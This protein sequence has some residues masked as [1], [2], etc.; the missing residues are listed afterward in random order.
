MSPASDPALLAAV[1]EARAALDRLAWMKPD[2]L[3]H[4][5]DVRRIEKAAKIA[6]QARDRIDAAVA[7]ESAGEET[8]GESHG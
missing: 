7:S 2:R 8:K 5:E 6:A 4:G 3:D 1:R